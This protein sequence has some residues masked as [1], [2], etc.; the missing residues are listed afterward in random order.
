MAES[1]EL[2]VSTLFLEQ[3]RKALKE[4]NVMKITV[5]HEDSTM[6]T[7]FFMSEAAFIA[8]LAHA[9]ANSKFLTGLVKEWPFEHM[10]DKARD[11]LSDEER[12]EYIEW[13]RTN[14][15]W[16]Q[17]LLFQLASLDVVRGPCCGRFMSD[18]DDVVTPANSH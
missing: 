14:P 4:N 8:N 12:K 9:L 5:P 3:L 10:T 6:Q 11:T 17:Q 16:I 1:V 13:Y 2:P 18:H 7:G 15:H